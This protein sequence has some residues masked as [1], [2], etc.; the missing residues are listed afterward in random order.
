MNNF[1]TFTHAQRVAAVPMKPIVDPAG[2]LPDELGDVASW[3]YQLSED[4][5]AE[6]TAAVAAFKKSG[7]PIVDVNRETF[8]LGPLAATLADV[9]RE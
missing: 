2:W 9:R 8:P 3:S 7:L 1:R 6:L 5:V 4:D